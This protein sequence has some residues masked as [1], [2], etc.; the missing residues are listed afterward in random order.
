MPL[1]H[2]RGDA[3]AVRPADGTGRPAPRRGWA[4]I[5]PTRTPWSRQTARAVPVRDE[6]S[7]VLLTMRIAAGF[8]LPSTDRAAMAE[9]SRLRDERGV[10]AVP[11]RHQQRRR[12]ARFEQVPDRR[13]RLR[14]FAEHDPGRA[15]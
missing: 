6:I 2:E 15:M 13:Q 9:A 14:Q 3:S 5:S 4:T 8:G 10:D 12:G 1:R 7:T 11:G